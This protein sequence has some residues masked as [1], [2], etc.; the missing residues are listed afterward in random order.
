MN[1]RSLLK[2]IAVAPVSLPL[3]KVAIAA[4]PEREYA[5]RDREGDH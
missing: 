4:Q 3:L 1:R 5:G 2:A